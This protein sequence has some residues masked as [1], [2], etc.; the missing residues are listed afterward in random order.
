[1][2][3]IEKAPRILYQ[4]TTL[5]Y[6]VHQLHRNKSYQMNG[7]D[8]VFLGT[9]W[10]ESYTW[11]LSLGE[12]WKSPPILLI[13][14]TNKLEDNPTYHNP[15]SFVINAVNWNSF[16]I[17]GVEKPKSGKQYTMNEYNTIYKDIKKLEGQLM[18]IKKTDIYLNNKSIVKYSNLS[19]KDV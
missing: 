4:G 7:D 19:L 13:I 17:L 16:L 14:D 2:G 6:L 8:K 12:D 11:A 10:F 3:N 18:K 15:M 1:M 9:R 5:R